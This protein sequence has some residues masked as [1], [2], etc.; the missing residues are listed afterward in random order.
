MLLEHDDK[1]FFVTKDFVSGEGTYIKI[2]ESYNSNMNNIAN[3]VSFF[4]TD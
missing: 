2:D 4:W 3:R 1:H